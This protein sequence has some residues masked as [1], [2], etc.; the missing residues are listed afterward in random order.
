MLWKMLFGFLALYLLIMLAMALLQ[1][2]LLY[3]PSS[4]PAYTHSPLFQVDVL[5]L[6][7]VDH[8]S[9]VMWYKPAR[10]GFPTLVYFHGNAGNLHD[11]T[12]KFRA[13]TDQGFGLAALSY[14]GYGGSSGTPT[15]QGLYTDA[16]TIIEWAKTQGIP[17]SRLIFYGESLGTGVAVRMATEHQPAALVLEAP[18]TSVVKRAHEIY[19]IFPV[20]LIMRDR[21]DSLS[22]I[23]QVKAPLL[24][25]HGEVDATIPVRHG[26][27]LLAAANEP[28]QGIFLP[29]I[30]HTD[31]PMDD[32]A[33]HLLTFAKT[34]QLIRTP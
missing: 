19:P 27:T 6:H 26:R 18:Y 30:G 14:R 15:E 1:R 21:F 29:G 3:L 22:R 4:P 28:K 2:K 8:H 11:R 10:A 20:P 7:T 24:L 25:I 33:N 34:H 31:F 13:Y 16:R 23:K 17:E 32:M 5:R 12:G 9:L